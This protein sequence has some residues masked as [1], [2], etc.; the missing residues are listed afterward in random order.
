M[1]WKVKLK[2]KRNKRERAKKK[3]KRIA[4]KKNSFKNN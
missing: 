4:K 1:M 2:D 3:Y